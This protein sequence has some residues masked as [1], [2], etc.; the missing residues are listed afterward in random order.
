MSSRTTSN[1]EAPE[2][3]RSTWAR[4]RSRSGDLARRRV[5]HPRVAGR[6]RGR[7]APRELRIGGLLRAAEREGALRREFA[8]D[9]QVLSRVQLTDLACERAREPS[10]R[11]PA[12]PRYGPT[13]CRWRPTPPSPSA[14]GRGSGRG[15]QLRRTEGLG[16]GDEPVDGG[17][18]DCRLQGERHRPR[19][20]LHAV[21]ALRQGNARAPQ[22]GDGEHLG[23]A[24]AQL[25]ADLVD[26]VLEERNAPFD[27]AADVRDR[28]ARI[29]SEAQCRNGPS[30]RASSEV[31]ERLPRPL[32]A[33]PVVDV[34]RDEL[35]LRRRHHV[36]RLVPSSWP[37]RRRWRP[38]ACPTAPG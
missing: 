26:A 11:G 23:V 25:A 38:A 7:R 2:G 18:L 10:G 34:D 22:R 4:W 6:G 16:Q 24:R 32:V 20:E 8:G 28:V 15:S 1:E 5:P 31:V 29:L 13:D 30:R 21:D 19:T 35:L 37:S 33:T 17:D 9:L 27:L 36:C 12:R 14:T 3:L